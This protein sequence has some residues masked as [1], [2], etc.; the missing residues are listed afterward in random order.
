VGHVGSE[1]S[2]NL[3]GEAFDV[4]DP[5][6]DVL[7]VYLEGT[8]LAGE[9]GGPFESPLCPGREPKFGHRR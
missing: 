6:E 5:E 7:C 1:A 9:P 4:E 8:L 2:K 3:A